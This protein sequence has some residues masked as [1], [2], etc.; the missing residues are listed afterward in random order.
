MPLPHNLK[1][2]TSITRP[3]PVGLCDR[4]QELRYL[5]DLWFQ[6]E[7]LGNALRSLNI[8]VCFDHCLDVPQELNRPILIGPDP[9]PLKDAR[10]GWWAQ[11]E[12]GGPPV[13]SPQSLI[14]D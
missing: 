1:C 4:C 6:Y 13:P 7:Y 12:Q 10:P 9:K 2:P 8:R 5:D 11:Q 3:R 14:E